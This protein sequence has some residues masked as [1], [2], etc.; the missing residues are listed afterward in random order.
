M[1]AYEVSNLNES[2]KAFSRYINT[3]VELKEDVQ[4]QVQAPGDDRTH[5]ITKKI[6]SN[7]ILTTRAGS[8]HKH[9]G[10][11]LEA[12][13]S[14]VIVSLIFCTLQILL[15]SVLRRKLKGLYQ[16][17]SLVEQA[18]NSGT[19]KGRYQSSMFGWLVVAW[20]TPINDY[21][22]KSMDAFFFLRF[23]RSICY[24][25]LCL[26]IVN[27]P[28]LLPIHYCSGH[29]PIIQNE[30]SEL[31]GYNCGNSSKESTSIT[32][33]E[34]LFTETQGLDKLSMSN[35]SPEHSSR[36]IFH[37]ILSI[38][39]V[40][41]FHVL[42]ISELELYIGYKNNALLDN[43][44]LHDADQTILFIDNIPSAMMND[45]VNLVK[46]FNSMMPNCV[47]QA[48]IIPKSY[49]KF[50]MHRKNQSKIID[51]IESLEIQHLMSE[52]YHKVIMKELF[53][54][55]SILKGL[56]KKGS[57]PSVQNIPGKSEMEK[58]IDFEMD[59]RPWISTEHSNL[60]QIDSHIF[61]KPVASYKWSYL[62]FLFRRVIQVRLRLKFGYRKNNRKCKIL[63]RTFRMPFAHHIPTMKLNFSSDE[64][65]LH[66]KF[67][68]LAKA[69]IDNCK[70][71]DATS[72]MLSI[73]DIMPLNCFHRQ[74]SNNRVESKSKLNKAFVQ[75]KNPVA[76]HLFHHILLSK[77]LNE[78]NNTILAPNPHDIVWSNIACSIGP[79]NLIRQTFSNFLS[80][81]VTVGWVVPVAIIGLFSH[82]PF[83]TKSVP[84]FSWI[85]AWPSWVSDIVSGILPILTL[86]FLTDF[87]PIIF[88]FLSFI[89]GKRTG[90]EMEI[91][92]QKWLFVFHFVHIFL[93]VT[94]SSGVS[95]FVEKIVNNPVSIPNLL[96][97]NLPKSANFF[98]SF[99][100]IRGMA[101]SSG[102]LLQFK[103]LIM[104]VC[105]YSIVNDT[106]RKMYRR[107]SLVPFYNWGSIF[108]LF[109]ALASIGLVYSVIAPLISLFSS[110]A[111]G[112]VYISFKCSLKF[113]HCPRYKTESLGI[114]YP[115]ALM[116]L[117]AG[118]YCSEIC[119]I[120]LFTISNRY[121][122]S[123][124]MVLTFT[125]TIIAHL[126]ISYIYRQRVWNLPLS[127][128]TSTAIKSN[129]QKFEAF[130]FRRRLKTL[131]IPWSYFQ[132]TREGK[133]IL[134]E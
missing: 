101:Y 7:F 95:I 42:L 50:Q 107:A 103:D 13:F 132:S 124:C 27:I 131:W 65:D 16:F 9:Y 33:R 2:L 110:V 39:V 31:Q 45:H 41:W 21:K 59:L 117:Y 35:I 85:T 66:E 40:L 61:N 108:P 49:K 75:F 44:T 93:V 4:L 24:F 86:M 125:F 122:L 90:T 57:G 55:F 34:D 100:L 11:T 99:I 48:S 52:K 96:A 112:L 133:K 98:Y 105:Y 94:V 14:S 38:F 67:D 79:L 130:T 88:R 81:I 28:I 74:Y 6:L 73:D 43:E 102:N 76:A 106:P 25:F 17:N 134:D 68:S 78:M 51:Q 109:S 62:Q 91:D 69:Y 92:V 60:S 29:K 121:N 120:G 127:C 26:S 10:I 8:A 71:W 87:V 113:Q 19:K 36:L 58:F 115:Q 128:L 37:L 20:A 1:I 111:F 12:F 126:Q 114:L 129:P 63:N 97:S 82:I 56:I 118:I 3:I 89:K 72:R 104:E 116:Q 119:L 70:A 5:N 23:L 54:S 83:L 80:V 77:N 32:I 18:T 30:I 22:R 123:I 47:E 84:Y 53:E 15:F 46:F 64:L